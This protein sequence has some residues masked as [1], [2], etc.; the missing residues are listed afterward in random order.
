MGRHHD[1]PSEY[2]AM[3]LLALFD[4]PVKTKDQR[5]RYSRF[6]TGLLRL[7]FTMVQ[8]SIYAQYC[9]SEEAAETKRRT[10]RSDLPG[11][12]QVRLLAVTDKQFAKME[13]FQ[14]R[15]PT[16]PESEPQQLTFF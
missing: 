7:G 14:G 4:L 11:E 3:W 5:K 6:R 2:K 12:G 16:A 9:P 13:I 10:I 8:F 1:M 15:T